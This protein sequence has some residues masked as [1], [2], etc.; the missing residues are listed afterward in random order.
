MAALKASFDYCDGA[1]DSLTDAAAVQQVK[2]FGRPQTK[3]SALWGNL[4]HDNEMYG[5]MAVY[6]RLKGLVPPTSERRP[7]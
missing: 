1:Y 5:Y 4:V 3:L 2:I 6:L 7:K